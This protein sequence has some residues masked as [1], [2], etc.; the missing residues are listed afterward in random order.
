MKK[1]ILLGIIL[2]IGF[3][4]L[5]FILQKDDNNKLHYYYIR[6]DTTNINGKLE[7]C[8]IGDHITEFKIKGIDE[9]FQFAPY[10]SELNG[11]HIFLYFAEKGDI[12]IKPS[13]VDTLKLIKDNEVYLYTFERF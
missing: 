13:N 10:T 6:F 5:I 8:E 7:Y 12:I 4:V 1:I 3:I 9:K 2:V 11:N